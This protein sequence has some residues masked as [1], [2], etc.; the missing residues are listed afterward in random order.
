METGVSGQCLLIHEL[1]GKKSNGVFVDI[2][3]NDGVTISNTF[4]FEKKFGFSGIAIE[5]IPSIFEK[6]KD[7]RGC[8]V[9][10]GCVTP[11]SGQAKFLEVFGAP[12]MLSTLAVHNIGLTARRLRNNAKRHHATIREIDVTCYTLQSL[13]KQFNIQQ[14]DFLSLDTEGGELDILKSIDFETLPVKVIS[15]ENN[16]YTNAVRHYLEAKGFLYIGTFKVD[17]IYL[18][19]GAALQ[20]TITKNNA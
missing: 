16:F 17:E 9:V 14:I 7:N 12:N 18:F 8:H 5:P 3:A 6:L 13:T 4:Y 1:L 10:C 15:V 19:G 11:K 20:Q 2:G